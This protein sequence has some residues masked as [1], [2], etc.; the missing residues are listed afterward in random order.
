VLYA[1]AQRAAC[2]AETLAG[3]RPDLASLAAERAVVGT[4]EPLRRPMVPAAW[5]RHRV[6]GAFRLGPGRW[7][8]LRVLGT[9][10][11][12]RVAFAELA[13]SL[14]LADVDLGAVAGQVP[15]A[16]QEHRLT[17]AISRWAFDQ[18]FGGIVYTSRLHQRYVCWAVFEGTLLQLAGPSV[19][20]APDDPD[21]V[22]VARRFGLA[23]EP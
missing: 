10:Q 5:W 21:F 12:L 3:F 1:A 18:G 19:P 17:Q 2:F 7:L 14:G 6:V 8:D 13:A 16:G 22:R 20:I 4:S 11:V 15:I 9:F 23:I